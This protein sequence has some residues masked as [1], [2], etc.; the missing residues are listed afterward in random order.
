MIFGG[1]G[2]VETQNWSFISKDNGKLVVQW[3]R[4][5]S[6]RHLDNDE[7]LRT[8]GQMGYGEIEK[9]NETCENFFKGL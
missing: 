4:Q 5:V 7:N 1:G 3:S 2:W 8:F 9:T 6:N